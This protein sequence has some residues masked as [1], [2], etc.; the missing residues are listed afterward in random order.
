MAVIERLSEKAEKLLKEIIKD[1]IPEHIAIIMDGN[2]RWA[3]KRRLRRV[4]GHK[5][6][7][8]A[9]RQAVRASKRLDR[10]R[11]L[12]LYAFSMEN[13]RRPANEI[14]TL[15]TIL[16]EFLKKEEKEMLDNDISLKYIGRIDD[17]PES[18]R[19]ELMRVSKSTENCK[20][21]TLTLALSYSGRSEIIDAVKKM[22]EDI[23]SGKRNVAIDEESFSEYLYTYNMPDPDLLIRTGGEMR[24]SNFLL[25]QIAYTELFIMD[26]LWPDFKD[27]NL[28]E[29][30]LD[31]QKRE[32]RFGGVE[33][34]R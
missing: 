13:W 33:S 26:V 11:Y 29:A 6:G 2:G 22:A 5:K 19:S 14:S 18:T 9:V 28:I 3:R 1:R 4:V 24:V 21:L 34:G 17:L 32:R 25:W 7:T 23:K 8:E 15:M 30:V 20:S 12:T 31:Y 27:F 10:V 16:E